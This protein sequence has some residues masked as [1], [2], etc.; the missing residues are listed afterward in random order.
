MIPKIL[1]FVWISEG[2]IDLPAEHAGNPSKW[3]S[4]NPGWAVRLWSGPELEGFVSTHYPSYLPLWNSLGKAVK[5][6]DLGR[7][8]LLHHFGGIYLD[9]DL[10]PFSRPRGVLDSF[11][12]SKVVYNK[13]ITESRISEIPSEDFV[14]ISSYGSVFSRENCRIDRAGYGVANNTLMMAPGQPWVMDF[15]GQQE[16]CSGG[17]VLEFLGPWAMTRFWRTRVAEDPEKVKAEMTII[18][19]HYFI[20]EQWRMSSQPPSY[21]ISAHTGENTWGDKTRKDWWNA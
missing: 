18:P 1:H 5:K 21:A 12:G 17:P 6:S 19:P 14:D 11:A 7:L 3:E 8:L 13:H 4:M 10:E 16:E 9:W 20:W 2:G 15:I